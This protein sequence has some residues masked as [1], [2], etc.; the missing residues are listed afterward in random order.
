MTD[1]SIGKNIHKGY[2]D[3]YV[4]VDETLTIEEFLKLR[5]QKNTKRKKNCF[6]LPNI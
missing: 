2:L 5:T 1:R 3:Q 4:E 6:S